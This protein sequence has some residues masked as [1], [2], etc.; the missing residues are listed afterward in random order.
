MPPKSKTTPKPGNKPATANPSV[1]SIFLTVY[2]QSVDLAPAPLT[3]NPYSLNELRGVEAVGGLKVGTS[4]G[5][6]YPSDMKVGLASVDFVEETVSTVTF[7]SGIAETK[8][9]KKVEE[10]SDTKES[11]SKSKKHDKHSHAHANADANKPVPKAPT[12]TEEVVITL[13]ETPTNFLCNITGSCVPNDF[14]QYK[15]IKERNDRYE[16]I[17]EGRR[18]ADNLNERHTQTINGESKAKKSQATPAAKTDMS[19]Q[20]TEWDI[21]DSFT[22]QNTEAEDATVATANVN[23]QN[24]N[25][26]KEATKLDKLVNSFQSVLSSPDCVLDVSESQPATST[27]TTTSTSTSTDDLPQ[28]EEKSSSA[29]ITTAKN[30]AILSSSSLKFSLNLIERAVQQNLFHLSHLKYRDYPAGDEA[31]L[32]A[33]ER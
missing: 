17:L 33:V 22:D 12:T 1:P 11:S 19:V 24:S 29:I 16:K 15:E 5:T 20:A 14:P 21:Y 8:V 26:K 2:G 10:K 18:N 27:T 30:N 25:T 28:E 6:T 9:E 13:T 4:D 3:S 32:E 7:D 31:G 23:S